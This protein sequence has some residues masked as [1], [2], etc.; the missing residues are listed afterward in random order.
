MPRR[1]RG[2]LLGVLL[3]SCLA[4]LL[5]AAVLFGLVLP[6][7]RSSLMQQRRRVLREM[8][9]S[10]WSILDHYE[11]LVGTGQMS[12]AEAEARAAA[13]VRNIRYGPGKR[14]YFWINDANGVVVM[15]P[16]MPHLEGQN[17]MAFRDPQGGRPIAGFVR[18]V[19]E[20]G[21]GFTSY[22]WQWHG[23]PNR[24]EPKL[25][26][27]KAF[28]PWGW[29]IGTGMYLEDVDA[30]IAAL[31]RKLTG[32]LLAVLLAVGFLA[33]VIIRRL[34][35]VER[36]RR[37]IEEALRASEARAR[38]TFEQ[39]AAGIAHLSLEDQVLRANPRFCAILGVERDRAIGADLDAF[40]HPEDRT[41]GAE[42]LGYVLAGEAPSCTLQRRFLRG[43][44]EIVWGQLTVSL[45]RDE[46]G[47][48]QYAIAVLHDVSD[49]VQM[50]EQLRHSQKMEALGQLA[51]GV[52]H[53]FNNQLTIIHGYADLLLVEAEGNGGDTMPLKEIRRAADRARTLTAQLLAFGRKQVLRTEVVDVGELI[54]TMRE[55]LAR[56]LGERVELTVSAAEEA[57]PIRVDPGQLE[58]AVMNLAINARDAMDDGG[59]LAIETG[60]HVAVPDGAS[61]DEADLPPGRYL[62]LSVRDTGC[63]MDPAVRDRAFEPFFTTKDVGKGTGLGLSMV[64]AFVQQSGGTVELDSAPDKGTTFRLYFPAC[65]RPVE[66]GG[67]AGDGGAAGGTETILVVED[68]QPVRKFIVRVLR[69]AGYQVLEARNADEALAA[70]GNGQAVP[71][72]LL[73]DVAMPGL[74]GPEL[75]DRLREDRP[76]LRVLFISGYPQK[77]AGGPTEAPDAEAFLSKPFRPDELTAAVRARLDA[78]TPT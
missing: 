36:R 34:V 55:P 49:R 52:A 4:L 22:Y 60:E 10:V 13:T 50:E 59:K 76:G 42:E 72:L 8:T 56:I 78:E 20:R 71:D 28:E 17:L 27:V 31:N 66:G 75:A 6:T 14:S 63:G 16:Y 65:E 48:P 1:L 24:V 18:I 61:P 38:A 47:R 41:V 5:L 26:F 12:R 19:R 44:G 15:H 67:D 62:R 37:E 33:A 46:A 21:E 45:C 23:D 30:E 11:D 43:D 53:D 57:P 68:E 70:L 64:Y 77:A 3:P 58:Q 25:S 35:R 74:T 39:A 9:T 73:T 40:T 69:K 32:A 7:F 29:V 51:G 54:A 2:P